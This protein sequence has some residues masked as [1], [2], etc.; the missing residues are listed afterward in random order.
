MER[1]AW[2]LTAVGALVL[3]GYGAYSALGELFTDSE[4]PVSVVVAV[5]LLI[6]GVALLL[7]VALK[8]RIRA[9]RQEDF[10][11]DDV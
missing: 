4:S 5:P 6:S 8:D 7:F 11:K 10:R 9:R 2:V 3:I 1:A